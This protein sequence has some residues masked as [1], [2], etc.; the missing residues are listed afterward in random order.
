MPCPHSLTLGLRPSA[1]DNTYRSKINR[2]LYLLRL[3]W[4]VF[5]NNNKHQYPLHGMLIRN[6]LGWGWVWRQELNTQRLLVGRELNAQRLWQACE[7]LMTYDRVPPAHYEFKPGNLQKRE[8]LGGEPTSTPSGRPEP[9]S[10]GKKERLGGEPTLTPW[11]RLEP[12][13]LGKEERLGGEPTPWG[14]LEPGSLG[15]KERLSSEPTPTPWGRLELGSPGKK[16]RFSGE[17][18]PRPWGRREQGSFG[19]KETR[20]RA[21]ANAMREARARRIADR[22]VLLFTPQ[23]THKSS[24]SERSEWCYL[25]YYTPNISLYLGCI[26]NSLNLGKSPTF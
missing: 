7:E 10:L 11:R 18:T 19:K 8:R 13:S 22:E 6:G 2:L 16:E 24:W 9:G 5:N 21:N 4:C 25:Y 3:C 12:G 15:K 14:R 1:S 17:P 23:C 26:V 20:R